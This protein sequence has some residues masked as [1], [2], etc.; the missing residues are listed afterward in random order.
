[1]HSL[2]RVNMARYRQRQCNIGPGVISVAVGA[3]Q[4]GRLARHGRDSDLEYR[5]GTYN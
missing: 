1:M 2:D 5:T 3:R 4:P